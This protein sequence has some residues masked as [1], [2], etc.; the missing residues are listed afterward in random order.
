MSS[1]ERSNVL[2]LEVGVNGGV[3]TAVGVGDDGT[4]V[5][6]GVDIKVS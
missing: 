2:L 4:G 5:G 6:L 3:D 1:N